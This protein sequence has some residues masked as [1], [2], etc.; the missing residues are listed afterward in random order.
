MTMKLK[1]K[2]LKL[3]KNYIYFND[4][5]YLIFKAENDEKARDFV[6]NNCDLSFNPN[7]LEIFE[8][9]QEGDKVIK[10][11]VKN[12]LRALTLKKFFT[13]CGVGEGVF[14]FFQ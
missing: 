10:F 7:V 11:N 2:E 5:Q 14:C 9:M 6:I 4:N 13:L 8:L 1:N 3:M 12:N